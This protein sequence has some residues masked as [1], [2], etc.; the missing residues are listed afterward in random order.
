MREPNRAS[1][2][3]KSSNVV[4]RL[5][6]HASDLP[7]KFTSSPNKRREQVAKLYRA[8]L[9]LACAGIYRRG[10]QWEGAH[11]AIQDALLCDACPEEVFTEVFQLL[12]LLIIAWIPPSRERVP[13]RSDDKL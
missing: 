8:K 3:T 9:W 5:S 2:E 7:S 13:F 12:L 1:T 10:R 6:N 11:A 4:Q